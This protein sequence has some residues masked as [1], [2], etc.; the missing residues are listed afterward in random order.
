MRGLVG[1][2]HR[3]VGYPA[4]WTSVLEL[5]LPP[6]T[7]MAC[8]EGTYIDTFR[9]GVIEEAIRHDVDWICFFDDDHI[10]PPDAIL[11]MLAHNVDVVGALAL[12]RDA[13]YTAI[14]MIADETTVDDGKYVALPEAWY[15][16]GQLVEVDVLPMNATLIRMS[17]IKK[18]TAP[19]FH[20][21]DHGHGRSEDVAFSEDARAAGFRLFCDTGLRIPH[22]TVA[23]VWI[24]AD[25]DRRF[26]GLSEV[27]RRTLVAP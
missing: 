26:G 6:G 3:S 8:L 17:V 1:I 27:D 21:G 7:I 11:R 5:K 15:R 14:P 22:L 2:G 10:L 18:L 16:T 9:N 23:A 24:T 12:K 20:M 4:F 25:G 19:W 13:P